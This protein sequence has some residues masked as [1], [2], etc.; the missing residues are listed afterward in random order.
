MASGECESTDEITTQSH[1]QRTPC[2]SNILVS[3]KVWRIPELLTKDA[4]LTSHHLF[5]VEDQ[6]TRISFVYTLPFFQG[7]VIALN[8]MFAPHVSAAATQ[9]EGQQPSAVLEASVDQLGHLKSN[10]ERD[11]AVTA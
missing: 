3:E 2:S 8:T 6:M 4:H 10:A 7:S 1:N 9:R 5:L 11:L